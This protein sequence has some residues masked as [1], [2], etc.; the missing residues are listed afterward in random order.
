M[1]VPPGWV[2]KKVGRKVVYTSDAP[3]VQIWNIRDFDR[4]K[5]KGRF[6][7]VNRDTLNFSNKV[8]QNPSRTL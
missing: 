8:S 1:K 3:K 2:R 4:F 5:Q 7:S 6:L